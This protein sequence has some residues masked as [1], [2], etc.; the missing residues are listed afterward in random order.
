MSHW[1][2][3]ASIIL[4]AGTALLVEY[5]IGG[6][7]LRGY[8]KVL[9][10][11]AGLCVLAACTDIAAHR[12]LVWDYGYAHT[13]HFRIVGVEIETIGFMLGTGMAVVIAALLWADDLDNGRPFLSSL[14]RRGKRP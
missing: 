2:Y 1:L 5:L 9:W 3:G 12:W 11:M 4:F 14:R 10:I 6:K 8:S 13:L 7:R